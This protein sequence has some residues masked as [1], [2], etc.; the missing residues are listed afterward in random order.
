MLSFFSVFLLVICSCDCVIEVTGRVLDK[1]TSNPIKGVAV[2]LL[3]GADVEKTNDKG[4]FEVNKIT[5]FC[6]DPL[7]I[8]TSTGY[9]PFQLEIKKLKG[10]TQYFVKTETSWIDYDQPFFPDPSNKNTFIKGQW[11][12]KWSQDFAIHDTLI[13]YLSKDNLTLEIEKSQ[14]DITSK[15][16]Y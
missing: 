8:V 3:R 2:D 4:I 13:I 12:D 5:G 16:S 15:S 10:N 9:K 14:A 1:D 6:N 7:I 11:I